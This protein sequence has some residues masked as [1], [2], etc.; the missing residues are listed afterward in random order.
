MTLYQYNILKHQ[1]RVEILWEYGV[2]VGERTDV[3]HRIILYQLDSFYVE[4]YYHKIYNIIKRYRNF[5]NTEL[6][7]PYLEQI[8]LV[9]D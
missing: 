8:K 9:I 3:E 1:Q 7:M 2:P 6:L 5:N 4:V